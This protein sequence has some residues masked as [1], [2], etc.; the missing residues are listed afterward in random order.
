M[1][2]FADRLIE[3]IKNKGNP[4]VIGID[5]RMELF[6]KAIIEKTDDL[7]LD[8]KIEDVLFDWG[9]TVIDA[10]H[11]IVPAVKIQSAFFEQYGVPGLWAMKRLI[12]YAK[13]TG[14]LVI[15]DAKR[16][17]IGSTAEAYAN[18]YIG[19]TK[20]FGE[21][22]MTF[23][24]DALTVSPFLGRDSLLPFVD[25]CKE[26]GTGIF[27]LVKNSNAGSGDFQDVKNA[28]GVPMYEAIAKMV[29]DIGTDC[30]GE[31]GYSSIGAVVGATYPEEAQKLRTLM[32]KSIILVP[33]YGAQGGSAKD[34]VSCFNSDMLGAIVNSSRGITFNGDVSDMTRE[35]Y[36][37]AVRANTEKMISDIKSVLNN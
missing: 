8:E 33:G 23:G 5:P 6:P 16:N 30:I 9:Y 2:N 37:N 15:L 4:C 13:E 29:A 1:Q 3:A 10:V 19:K 11:D 22:K 36:S 18:A 35:D 21:D 25:V 12:S 31:S 7:T 34:T 32:P 28:E 27:I 17:D 20:I 24:A 14:L 26:N